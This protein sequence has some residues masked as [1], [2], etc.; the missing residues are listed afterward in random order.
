MAM[1][2]PLDDDAMIA[3]VERDRSEDEQIAFMYKLLFCSAYKE[4]MV[5]PWVGVWI[6]RHAPAIA[7]RVA[8]DFNERK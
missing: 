2:A 4:L 1:P 7:D 3:F 8:L 6:K 5:Q